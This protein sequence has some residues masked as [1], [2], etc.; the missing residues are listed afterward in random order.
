MSPEDQK[1][2]LP[3]L[4]DK[5][6]FIVCVTDVVGTEATVLK[7]DTEDAVEK[8]DWVDYAVITDSA[9]RA[10]NLEDTEDTVGSQDVSL[11]LSQALSSNPVTVGSVTQ[12]S[13]GDKET[14]DTETE[15]VTLDYF[16]VIEADDY[17][18]DE[19]FK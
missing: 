7:E 14:L 4:N 11:T 19:E 10:K 3:D 8:G 1:E 12:G 16:P 2:F 13:T 9:G 6:D 18:E 17:N 5:D 15:E